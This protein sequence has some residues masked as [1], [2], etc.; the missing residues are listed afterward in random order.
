MNKGLRVARGAVVGVLNSDDLYADSH[1]VTELIGALQQA[2]VDAVFADLVYVDQLDKSRV[3]RYYDSSRWSPE[4]FRFGWM[5]AHPTLFVKRERYARC[6]PFSLDYQIAADFEM[7][8][9][10]FHRDRTTYTYLKRPVVYDAR[11]WCQYAWAAAKLDHQHGN[12]QGVQGEWYLDHSTA[13]AFKG[14]GK[15]PGIA[16]AKWFARGRGKIAASV[17]S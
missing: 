7:L 5:P 1:V 16:M 8:V 10:L 3:R 11:W 15:T 4:R 6:G 14:T 13:S 17:A 9:R 2:D 12:C